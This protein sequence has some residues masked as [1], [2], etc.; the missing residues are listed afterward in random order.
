MNINLLNGAIGQV[1]GPFAT[2]EILNFNG[3]E[4]K[5]GISIAEKDLMTYEQTINK[6]FVILINNELVKL[7][8]E[9]IY[10]SDDWIILNQIS[11]P[12]GA[13]PSILI[14]YVIKSE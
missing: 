13:P 6:G 9:G 10:E 7:G 2:N 12:Q 8:Y 14:E 11:F 5:L 4:V 1:Q 3:A